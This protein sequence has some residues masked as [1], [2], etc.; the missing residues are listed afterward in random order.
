M[1]RLC[2]GMLTLIL[3]ACGSSKYGGV[4]LS[5]LDETVVEPI[6]QQTLQ[7][8]PVE[9]IQSYRELLG[10]AAD[11]P[12][13]PR[14]MHR[15]GDLL[16]DYGEQREIKLAANDEIVA[17][18][19]Y[20]EAIT[21]YEEL[22]STYS[23]Y[24]DTDLVIYQLARVY[25]KQGEIDK[26]SQLLL[27]LVTEFRQS[28]YFI[29]AQFRL[30]ELS[31]LYGEYHQAGISYQAVLDAGET[32][33]FYEQSLL[34]YSW[35]VFKQ[36]RL[37]EALKSFYLL[38]DLKLNR[39]KFD[40]ITGRPTGLGKADEEILG[41]IL[42]GMTLIFALK[43]SPQELELFSQKN[44]QAE[45]NHLLY[46]SIAEIYHKEERYLNEAETYAAYISNYPES[47]HAA[48][49]Q[50]RLV[51]SY[52]FLNDHQQV[53]ATKEVFLNDFWS[54]RIDATEFSSEYISHIS[55]FAKSYLNDLTDFYHSRFQKAKLAADFDAAVNWYHTY[56]KNFHTEA[57]VIEKHFLLAELLFEN[58]RFQEAGNEYEQVA[59]AYPLHERAAEAGYSAILSYKKL[60]ESSE[61]GDT[62]SRRQLQRQSTLRFASNFPADSRV[63]NTLLVLASDDFERGDHENAKQLIDSLLNGE[64]VL[65][66]KASFSALTMLGHISFQAQDYL[67]A[68]QAFQSAREHMADSN[69]QARETE[70][71]LAASIYKQAEA[72]LAV[73]ETQLAVEQLLRIEHVAASSKLV[74]QAKY[75][76]AAELIGLENWQQ[77]ADL[78][79]LFQGSYPHHKFQAEIPAKL[80]YV[81]MKLNR[82]ADAAF[83]YEQIANH[84]Q[85]AEVQK[86]ALL[87]SARLYQQT[88][89]L[90]KATAIYKRYIY[91]YPELS[92]QAFYARSQLADIYVQL[93]QLK[94]RDYWLRDIVKSAKSAGM[95][96]NDQI[97]FIAAKASL[98]LAE[99]KLA[100]FDSVR[101]V[102]PL[103][104]NLAKKKQKME[105]ALAAYR[106][107][108]DYGYAESVTAATHRIGEIY[109]KLSTALLE[110]ARPNNLDDEELEQYEMMLEEQAYPFE[111]KAIE[112][113]ESNVER[114]EDGL[115]TDWMDK[116]YTTLG[117]LL[118]VQ[119]AKPELPSEVIDVLH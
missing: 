35:T 83:A 33:P 70:E 72:M 10:F 2:L 75:D 41:D 46:L 85:D 104:E 119:Y 12:F 36:D 117:I 54:P 80:A 108:S 9:T 6:V 62:D 23:D 109:F 91:K 55:N 95:Q 116:S 32:N 110:S 18:D 44:G 68:E 64:Q 22:I 94:S 114:V 105:L 113:L 60:L 63:S 50:L 45:Y 17:I 93:G 67:R 71:W 111:E 102:E 77:A 87:Q 57:N 97:K 84:N 52:R 47:H 90:S 61:D 31:F 25:D 7:S 21:V 28:K 3:A 19:E 49:F 51:D 74:A 38:I 39:T 106:K 40:P 76:A 107:T 99:N 15:L 13:R 88:G 115:Y 42:R 1:R 29:E 24:P 8:S 66:D 30:G 5:E 65:A 81:Y 112:F 26:T 82:T 37:D 103:R 96:K 98:T 43:N 69:K 34:K 59:Y 92:E 56:L 73:G 53:V 20:A 27:R 86:E 4:T 58:G 100:D 78:L 48:I 11:N 101:L 14:A 16:L 89:N 118:P 79:E